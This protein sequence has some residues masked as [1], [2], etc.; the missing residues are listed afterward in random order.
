MQNLLHI[1]HQHTRQ[2][3][4]RFEHI[5]LLVPV[6]LCNNNPDSNNLGELGTDYYTH[7]L[8]GL[9]AYSSNMS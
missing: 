2:H 7:H 9:F 5:E 1:L 4:N 8:G 6:R 3:S